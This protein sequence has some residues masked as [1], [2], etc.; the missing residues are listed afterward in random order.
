M[1]TKVVS[2]LFALAACL[3]VY[4]VCFIDGNCKCVNAGQCYGSCT[5][6][7]CST[8]TCIIADVT[9]YT[10]NACQGAGPYKGRTQAGQTWCEVSSCRLYNNCTQQYEF[11]PCG[12][13]FMVPFYI[14]SGPSC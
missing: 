12:C 3:G 4:G 1:R 6:D 13:W 5:P 10:P 7:G 14:P 2:L 8:P 11:P 9:T